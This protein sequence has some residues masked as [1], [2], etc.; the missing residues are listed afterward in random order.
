MPVAV[1]VA[2]N[3]D[4]ATE[5]FKRINSAGTPM[6]SFNM[7]SALAYQDDYN[8]QEEFEK[9]RTELLDP[10]G[11]GDI[12][13]SDLLRICVGLIP[14]E[15]PAKLRVN[16][17]A[18]ALRTDR[19][20]VQR[21]IEAIIPA[22]RLLAQFG[23]HGPEILPYSWQLITMA[24][25]LH[26]LYPNKAPSVKDEAQ[27]E[28]WFW[29]TTYGQ[30]FA[31]VNS[32]IFSRSSEAFEEMIVQ[33]TWNKMAQDVSREVVEVHRFDFRAARCKAC[34]LAMARLQ[35]N[36]NKEG[37]AHL[38]LRHGTSAIQ[39]LNSQNGGRSQWWNLAIVASEGKN[40]IKDYR[41]ALDRVK[42]GPTAQKDI[43]LLRAIGIE[44]SPEKG[45]STV[46]ELLE[47]RCQKIQESERQLVLGLGLNWK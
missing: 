20:L 43:Q 11:W 44:P 12:S 9:Y 31:G 26:A 24:L 32:S 28:K 3:L 21:G 16:E 13:D 7:V 45:S 2:E 22:A 17:A 30:V 4:Q 41:D 6:S 19:T 5:S 29:L 14:S 38:A 1:L 25:Q 10:M 15:N 46:K 40:S 47:K 35:D 27:I 37:P 39:V 33:G 18:K 8:P 36:D 23:I 42:D 34:I